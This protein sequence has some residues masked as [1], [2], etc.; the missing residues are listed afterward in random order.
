MKKYAIGIV[1]LA[2][3]AMAMVVLAQGGKGKAV[4]SSMAQTNAAAHVL[5]TPGDFKWGP[6]PPALPAG[7]QMALLDGDPGKA[8]SAYTLRVKIPDGYKIPPHWHPRDETI[9]VIEGTFAMGLGDKFDEAAG[10]E[11]V[12]GSYARMPKGVRHFAWAKGE[13]IIQVQGTGPFEI[14]YVNPADDPRR[15]K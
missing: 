5:L 2:L 9:T 7:A 8:G 15:T 6:S 3:S 13:S 10:H 1:V 4:K 12:A 11:L 14:T